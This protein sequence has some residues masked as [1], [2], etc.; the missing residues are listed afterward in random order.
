MRILWRITACCLLGAVVALALA[1]ISQECQPQCVEGDVCG[2]CLNCLPIGRLSHPQ[3]AKE[4]VSRPLQPAK[5]CNSLT[6]IFYP[7]PVLL[8]VE[9]PCPQPQ[10]LIQGVFWIFCFGSRSPPVSS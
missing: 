3:W 8:T 6:L 5:E 7:F 1:E 4:Q 9:P 10:P 2:D